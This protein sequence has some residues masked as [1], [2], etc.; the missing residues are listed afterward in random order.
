M[1]CSRTLQPNQL[2][3]RL[4]MHAGNVTAIAEIALVQ[5]R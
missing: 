4:V 2:A 3:A 1:R 5:F